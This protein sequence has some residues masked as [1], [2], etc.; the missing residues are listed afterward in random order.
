MRLQMLPTHLPHHVPLKATSN[1][2]ATDLVQCAAKGYSL[3][4]VKGLAIDI[5]HEAD[6]P[7]LIEQL[8]GG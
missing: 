6:P 1:P 3:L 5:Q 4:V 7:S 8:T 2:A